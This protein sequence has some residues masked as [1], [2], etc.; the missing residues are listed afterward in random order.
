[1]IVKKTVQNNPSDKPKKG[2]IKKYGLSTAKLQAIDEKKAKLTETILNNSTD[3]IPSQVNK[4]EDTVI[5]TNTIN[6]KE[7][8][9]NED[10]KEAIENN[11]NY[12]EYDENE[13]ISEEESAE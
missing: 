1:M 5:Q 10:D 6:E 3:G 12:G 13:E 2:D 8:I 7:R 11:E 9:E 4:T